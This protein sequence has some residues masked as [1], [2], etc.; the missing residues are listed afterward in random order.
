MSSYEDPD[1]G[2]RRSMAITA[3]FDFLTSSFEIDR[4]D[5]FCNLY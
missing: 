4:I 3:S 5:R 2:S 1:P